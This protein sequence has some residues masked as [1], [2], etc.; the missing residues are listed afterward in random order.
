MLLSFLKLTH[1]CNFLPFLGTNI[2]EY[3]AGDLL[4]LI[5]PLSMFTLI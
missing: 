5:K 4:S 3:L 1:N 2:T